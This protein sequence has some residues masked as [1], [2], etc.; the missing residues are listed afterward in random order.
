MNWAQFY[1]Q[2][3]FNFSNPRLVWVRHTIVPGED[4][5]VWS[6]LKERVKIKLMKLTIQTE[7]IFQ[8]F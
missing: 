2:T 5:G 1:K 6:R 7:T 3:N 8:R 4:C